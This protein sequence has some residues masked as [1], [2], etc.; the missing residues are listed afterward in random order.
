M[1][2][3]ARTIAERAAVPKRI[4]ISLSLPVTAVGK[5]FKPALVELE[6]EEAIR[7]EADR[8]GANVAFISVDRDPRIGVRAIVAAADGADA[9]REALGRYAFKSEV[10]TA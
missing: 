1:E 2:H 3:A 7:A 9:L 6:I 10:R 8:T 4:K 5:L